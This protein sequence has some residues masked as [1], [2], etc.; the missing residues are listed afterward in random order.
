MPISG[1]LTVCC[2]FD[3]ENNRWGTPYL[4][5]ESRN[6]TADNSGVTGRVCSVEIARA[7]GSFPEYVNFRQH[8]GGPVRLIS[9]EYQISQMRSDLTTAESRLQNQID[10]L[11]S[12]ISTLSQ[13]IYDYHH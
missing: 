3:E 10:G 7:V 9:Y 1:S 12:S 11:Q 2:V 13:R 5:D 8:Y 4:K 6:L